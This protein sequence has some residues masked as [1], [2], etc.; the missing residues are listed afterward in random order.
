MKSSDSESK[1]EHPPLFYLVLYPL[2]HVSTC[3]A[4]SVGI[5]CGLCPL[6]CWVLRAMAT[7]PATHTHPRQSN[8][9]E[10]APSAW[11]AV[12]GFG[13]CGR[14]DQ[15]GGH[16]SRADKGN[17][18]LAST[19]IDTLFL[20]CQVSV[21]PNLGGCGGASDGGLEAPASAT[22]PSV[23]S[24]MWSVCFIAFPFL[25]SSAPRSSP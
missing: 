5:F 12:S 25:L 24:S 6:P 10:G 3:L 9:G 17:S 13:P 11:G 14:G 1:L 2:V 20:F 21:T 23:P 4:R 7:P 22:G 19:R 8:R 15:P 16:A 18:V